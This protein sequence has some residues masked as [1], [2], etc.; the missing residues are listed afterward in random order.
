MSRLTKQV[1]TNF[2]IIIV[3]DDPV[4]LGS[5]ATLLE[6]EG[7]QV[8]RAYSG[9][10]AIELCREH[11]PQLMLLDYK[12]PKLTGKEVVRQVRAFNQKVQIVLQTG[13]TEKLPRT[14][15]KE[16]DIQ[17]YHDKSEGPEKL[18][19]WVDVALKSYEQ[20]TRNRDLEGSLLA[21]GL[22][23]EARDLET[24]GH[25]ERVVALAERLGRRLKLSPKQLSALRQGA[26]LHDL[27]KL[28]IPDAI[29]LK[30]G[31]LESDEWDLMKSH[32][33]KGFELA[34]L[35]SGIHPE[36]LLVIRHHHERWDGTGYPHGLKGEAIPLLAR[37]FALCDAL[38]ALTSKRP[39]KAA[40]PLETALEKLRETAG[41]HFDPELVEPFIE[42]LD[43]PAR[44]SLR[45]RETSKPESEAVVA[46]HA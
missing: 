20:M 4:L 17:G 40:W 35:V 45:V 6:R 16:L 27:G 10:Q 21:L 14:L 23:L 3:E 38:D 36:A 18:L 29:L 28:S 24:S 5:T 37:I 19:L 1:S 43:I 13:Y 25:T 41:S 34:S 39:Y 12:M 8:L 33:D 7:H 22:A 44:A 30:P 11:E 31:K 9:V 42:S 26:Y 32:S 2:K 46:W 15:L